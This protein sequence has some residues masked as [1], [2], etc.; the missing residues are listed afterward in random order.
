M[1]LPYRVACLLTV[2]TFGVLSPMARPQLAPD[3]KPARYETRDVHDPNGIGKFYMGREI[4]MVMGHQGAAWLERPEREKQEQ[5]TKLL[6]ILDLKP[7]TVVADIGAG[8]G[9]YSFRMAEKVGAK[10][11]VLAVDIQKEMLDIIRQRMKKE[12]FANIE[13]ILGTEKDPKL[14]NG[15]VDLILLVDVYHEFAF[16][17]EMTQA[18]LKALK[19]GGR[20]VFVEF[21]EEDRDPEVPILPAHRMTKK[22]VRAEMEQYPL[23]HVK[24]I[25]SL[26]WQHV[27]IFEKKTEKEE[28]PAK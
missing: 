27:I 16:P 21:R 19:P 17:F 24:T 25:S 22:Q 3:K 2:L 26:P 15:G 10:G 23:K 8:S 13:P 9:Y 11:K 6:K 1:R 12:E 7:N 20:L 4:A 5:P 28:K 14:P 18:M